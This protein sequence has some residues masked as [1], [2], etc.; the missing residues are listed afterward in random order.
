M[1]SANA[2]EEASGLKEQHRAP[3]PWLVSD[4]LLSKQIST[5]L[6][7]FITNNLIVGS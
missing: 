1:V 7:S 3:L 5:A 6:L 4:S 2:D